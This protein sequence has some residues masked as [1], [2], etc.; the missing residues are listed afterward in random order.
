VKK[1]SSRKQL[2]QRLKAQESRLTALLALLELQEA[3]IATLE[4]NYKA[5]A[6]ETSIRLHNVNTKASNIFKS[7]T[8]TDETVDDVVKYL[9]ELPK[10]QG[11]PPHPF[12][13]NQHGNE[14][15]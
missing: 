11:G 6:E 7:L 2:K 1:K 15:A 12:R 14:Q 9:K 8:I 4:K 3:Q 10:F 5:L 13:G